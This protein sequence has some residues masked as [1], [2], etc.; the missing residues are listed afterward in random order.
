MVVGRWDGGMAGWYHATHITEPHAYLHVIAKLPG[1]KAAAL[2]NVA[3]PVRPTDLW[4]GLQVNLILITNLS[5]FH[6]HSSSPSP[7]SPP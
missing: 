3:W 7:S 6:P 1:A 4:L 2:G 5:Q